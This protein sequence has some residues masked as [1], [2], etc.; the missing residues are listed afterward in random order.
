MMEVQ[1]HRIQKDI[2]MI[3][4]FNTTPGRGVTRFTFS[5][6]YM[7]A[8]SYVVE[9]LRKIGA[10]VFDGPAGN[11]RG[12]LEGSDKGKPAV[13]AGSHIDTVFQGGRFDGVVGVV[14]ALEAARVIVENGVAHRH[15][16]DVVIFAEEEGSRFQS[17][18]MGSRAWTG[19]INLNDL[20]RFKDK[21]GVSYLDAM[22][23]M[24][25]LLDENSILKPDEIKAML[26]VHIEQSLV[27]EK[28]G[29]S[30]GV[31]E[32]IAGI[33]QFLVTIEGVSNHAGGTPMELRFDALQ[34]AARIISAVEEIA[35]HEV[36]PNTVATVGFLKCEPGQVNVIPGR[37]QFT[38]DI[39]DT[40]S[41]LVKRASEKV[42]AVIAK[43][44]QDRRL[45]YDVAPRSDTPPVRLSKNMVRLIEDVAKRKQVQVIRIMSGALHDSSVMAEIT[46][47]GMI[48]VPSRGGRSHCP[49]EFTELEDIKL[50]AD[51]LLE[52]M[53]DLAS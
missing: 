22:K 38:L 46:E 8:R 34:G 6:P 26:E 10:T 30:V 51:I 47:V 32:A 2:E 37:V 23:Q 48:F 7:A 52:T 39:R 28:K 43:T 14:S 45:T 19:K 5:K 12:R 18:L 33:K 17:I 11:V 21:E 15:P 41:S 4:S 49:E 27:L 1:E 31:V 25:V 29:V 9:E 36:S 35:S 20:G 16:I 24:G 53:I 42:M 13:M 50:G 40:D 44:C 3:N